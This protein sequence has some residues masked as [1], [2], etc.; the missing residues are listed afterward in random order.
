MMKSFTEIRKIK[1]ESKNEGI[2]DRMLAGK[3]KKGAKHW[4]TQN[5]QKP[6]TTNEDSEYNNE[7]EMA[8]GQLK[9]I[10]DAAL[11]LHNMLKDDTNLPEWVQSKITKASDYIDTARD[12]MK[13]ELPVES[14]NEDYYAGLSKS[15]AAKR[16]AH[17]NKYGP[18]ADDKDSSYKPAPGDARAKTKLSKHTKKFRQMYGENKA[19]TATKERIAREKKADARKHDRMLD[20]ART[21][22]TRTKNKSTTAEKLDPKKHDAGDYVKDF[23]KSD[24]PQFKG[25]S[26]EKVRK[27]AVAAYLDARDKMNEG[28]GKKK[29]ESWEAGYKRRVIKTTKPE[30]K[31]K[32]YNWRIKGK[33][34]P[35]ISIKLYKNKP[36]QSEFNSQ[37]KRVAGHE[38]GSG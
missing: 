18:K 10:A 29:P 11:E 16:K 23:Q 14:T 31:E 15:T 38:F 20:R 9:T 24:A 35:E 37:M 17:F 30:H 6:K 3:T 36:S 8:K 19:M 1:S 32:G 33:E 7:G 22:D 25:K 4:V 5:S 12:Y 2:I 28:V 13:N 27:M 21:L 34:R 26:K